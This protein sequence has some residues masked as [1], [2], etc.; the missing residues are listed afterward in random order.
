MASE[1]IP[2]NSSTSWMDTPPRSPK[3]RHYN[4]Q[5]IAKMPWLDT[6]STS[7]QK[8]SHGVFGEPR[9]LSYRVKDFLAGVWFGHPVHPALVTIPIGSWSAS[10]I[11]DLAWLADQDDGVAR[12]SDLLMLV[13]LLSA[14]GA[15]TTGIANWVDTDG[16]D[17]RTGMLHALINSSVT[18]LNLSSLV[19][20]KTGQRRTAI[21]LAE[22]LFLSPLTLLS[23]VES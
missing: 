14:L 16:Q 13:G 20:R 18:A 8:L 17:Q 5:L 22:P 11:L 10:L 9:D 7:V 19:L 23:L 6:L 1:T 2:T 4:A 12:S 21:V 15:A 3:L